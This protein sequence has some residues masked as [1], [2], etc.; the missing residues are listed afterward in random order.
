M[1]HKVLQFVGQKQ[2]TT[3]LLAWPCN[4]PF[5]APNFNDSI[6]LASLYLGH[7]NVHL[8]TTIN[9]VCVCVC[10]CMYSQIMKCLRK[11]MNLRKRTERSQD[12]EQLQF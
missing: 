1:G 7:T 5:S 9:K 12:E 6:Y 2:G 10:V 3:V 4:K 8:V 11:I